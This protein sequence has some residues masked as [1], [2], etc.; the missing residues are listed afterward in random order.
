[1]TTQELTEPTDVAIPWRTE[2][3]PK[4]TSDVDQA[5]ADLQAWGFC[6]L[7][8]ALPPAQLAT[9]RQRLIEQA[10]AEAEAGIGR[11]DTGAHPSKY[12]GAGINQ[13]VGMLV[14][15]GVEFHE[16]IQ[17]PGVSRLLTALLG[18]RY[19]LTSYT[20]NITAPGCE[21]QLLHQDQGYVSWPQPAYP[22]VTQVLW[23][24][25]DMTDLN[26]GTRIVPG[27]HLWTEPLQDQNHPTIP[28]EAPAGTA[29]LM[30]GRLWHGAGANRADHLRRVLLSNFCRVWVRQQENPFLG[31]APEVEA[32]L[33]PEMRRLLGFRV[34][35]TLGGVGEPQ[36]I[37]DGFA[38]RPTTF[39]TRMS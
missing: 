39:T 32:S 27:S 7:A 10:R 17:H 33:S 23:T 19:L 22:I 6:Y 13:R 30:D 14:N 34:W 8:D 21:R 36:A 9:V 26:G 11:F 4:L 20:A 29:V 25:D 38:T 3:L 35:G 31:L 16:V 15:K 24:L 28:V 18:E 37:V 2:D 5:L 1:M 12:E